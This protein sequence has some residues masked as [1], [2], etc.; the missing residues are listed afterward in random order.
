MPSEGSVTRW[1]GQL[2]EGDSA[3]ARPLW[4]R[5]FGQ[6]VARARAALGAAP[7]RMADEE[8][9]ALS[10]FDSFCRGVEH[11]RFPRLDDRDDLWQV[12]LMLAARKTAHLIR[13]ERRAKRGGGQVRAEA[14]L[15]QG[16]SG[17]EAVL[18]QVMGREP[19]PE[20]AASVA[21]ECR[22]LLD[23]LGDGELRSI[24]IWEMEGYTVEEIA[25]RLGCSVRTVARKLAIIRDRWRGEDAAS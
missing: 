23:R 24:A 10:A 11:G 18:A 6:L 15:V 22:R 1:L 7:R 4:E 5:Y 2:R 9:L 16:E 25:A 21:E 8:D 12:L 20:L 3:A 17:E 14:D 19:T 13:D